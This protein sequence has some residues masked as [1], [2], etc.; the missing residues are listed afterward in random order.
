MMS[1]IKFGI[2]G[3]GYI[4]KRHC[5]VIKVNNSCELVAICDINENS[6]LNHQ[7]DGEKFY[8]SASKMI[9]DNPDIDVICVCTPNGLHAEHSLLALRNSKHVVI[10]KPIALN[11]KNAEQILEASIKMDRKVFCVMQ[12]RYSPPSRWLKEVIELGLLGKI[13]VVQLNCYWN[14]DNRYYKTGG[15][16]G[17]LDLDGGTL[18]TQFS[19]WI[20]I[21]YWVFGDIKNINARFSNFNHSDMIEFED[22]GIV[23]FEFL[24]GGFGCINYSTSAWDSNLESSITIIGERGSIKIGGQYMDKIE[25]CK[26]SDYE[27]PE[28]ESTNSANVYAGYVGSANNHPN[29]FENIIDVLHGKSQI[30]TTALDGLKVVEIIE[31]IYNLKK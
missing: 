24:N 23:S 14:R 17:T 5:N 2:I 4:G 26:I 11:V 22:T 16:K 6:I 1:K 20:D 3:F 21:L 10:E 18:F 19:H 15:W 31:K 12:N 7:F 25:T 30:T 28:L 27:A 13:Y 8:T 29:V 9:L